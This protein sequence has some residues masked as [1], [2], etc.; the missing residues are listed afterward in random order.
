MGEADRADGTAL[1]DYDYDLPDAAIA[2]RPA[3]P[4]DA[5][6]LLISAPGEPMRDAVVRDLPELLHAGDL[7]VVND[8]RVLPARLSGDRLRRGGGA[9]VELTLLEAAVAGPEPV[10]RAFARPAKRLAGGDR[11]LIAGPSPDATLH[12]TVLSRDGGEVTVRFDGDPLSVGAIPLP[13]YIAA[14]RSPDA[15]DAVDYQTVYAAPPGS[16]AA[17]TAGLHFTQPLIG[18][19]AARGVAMTTVT[20][21]VGA[22]TFRPVTVERIEAHAMHAEVGLVP[23]ATVEQVRATRAAGGRVV[24]VG[25]TALRL[26]ETAAQPDGLA[27]FAGSTQLFIRPGHRFRVVDALMT[28]FHLPRSTLLMLVAAFVGLPRMRAIYTHALASGYR[29]ASYG[30]ASLLLP[31]PAVL[32]RR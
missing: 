20:L 12:A 25:T 21:H 10:W 18:E 11:I 5:A 2:L 28:N 16:V 24:A 15:R 8:S 22:G 29:F 31:D 6:R 27:P 19:L 9:R 23:E 17:P 1:A 4:R 3:A 30:D 7:I 14:R 26:L 32:A 13:P